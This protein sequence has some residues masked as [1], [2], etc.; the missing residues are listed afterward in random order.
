[1]Y[2]CGQHEFS[3]IG[4]CMM[5]FRADFRVIPYGIDDLRVL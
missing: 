3:F 4:H 2:I 5:K 1:M